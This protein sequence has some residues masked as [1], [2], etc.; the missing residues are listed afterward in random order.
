MDSTVMQ[1]VIWLVA[2][3]AMYLFLRRRRT[4]RTR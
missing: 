3:G 1:A 2:G 4:R